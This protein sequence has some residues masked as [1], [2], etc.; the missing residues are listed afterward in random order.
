MAAP[1]QSPAKCKV[2][3]IIRFLNAKFN[4]DILEHPP[5]SPDLA[6]SD[7]HLFLH[8]KTHLAGQKFD[9]DEVQEEVM[10]VVQRAGSRLL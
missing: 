3:S 2:R 1:I 7:F 5:Y 4:W 6:P 8:L 10:R 9:E